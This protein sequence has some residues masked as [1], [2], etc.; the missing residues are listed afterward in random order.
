MVASLVQRH[1]EGE[2]DQVDRPSQAKVEEEPLLGEVEVEEGHLPCQVG[3][4][5]EVGRHQEAGLQAQLVQLQ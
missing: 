4:E 2:G 1:R 3:E 5:E